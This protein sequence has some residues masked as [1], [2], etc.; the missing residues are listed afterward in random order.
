M[1]A[2]IGKI[3]IQ[4]TGNADK[5]KKSVSYQKYECFKFYI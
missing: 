1:E 2:T 4:I 5:A 3:D